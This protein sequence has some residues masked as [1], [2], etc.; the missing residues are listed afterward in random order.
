MAS[1]TPQMTTRVQEI[2][3]YYP[4]DNPGTLTNLA[5]LLM[6]G[7]LAGT[8]RLVILPVDR[9]LSMGPTARLR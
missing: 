2:L 6:H 4:S 1:P 3:S 8:G 5:R 9:G 7:R